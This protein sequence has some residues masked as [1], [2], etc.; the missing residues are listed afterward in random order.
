MRSLDGQAGAA[1]DNGTTAEPGQPN[2]VPAEVTVSSITFR[3]L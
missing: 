3:A 1:I 2:P